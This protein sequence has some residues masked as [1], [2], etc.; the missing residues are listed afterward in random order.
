M[1]DKSL[2]VQ[3]M[4]VFFWFFFFGQQKKQV[5]KTRQMDA[6]VK[7]SKEATGN[8]LVRKRS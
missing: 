2:V 7:D 3:T 4:L 6:N 5:R 1:T 8:G